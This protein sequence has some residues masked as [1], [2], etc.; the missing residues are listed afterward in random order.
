MMPSLPRFP[1]RRAV[2][3]ALLTC[4]L[5]SPAC[6]SPVAKLGK[7]P[8]APQV[9]AT[10]TRFR[11]EYVLAPGDQIEV[12]VRRA[13][14]ASRTVAVRPDGNISLPLLQDVAAVGL[15]PR[16]LSERLRE[17]LSKRLLDPEVNVIPVQVRQP[18]VY[19]A[20]DVNA[21]AAVPL[22]EA[23]TAVQAITLAG[24]LRRS[25]VSRHVSIIR[26]N[27]EGFVEAIQIPATAKGQPGPYMA[28]RSTLLQPDDLIFV[29]ESGRS[30]S[31]R[32][33]EDFV[34]RP[35][36]G[37]NSVL[38]VYLNFRFVEALAR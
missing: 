28:L 22:R 9:V 10:A 13:P 38:G 35:L 19:V 6:I 36:V 17:G 16:E 30:Q 24:G 20:G 29:A 34:N 1:S 5:F 11:K 33:L 18:M 4:V 25:A 2:L 7:V 37:I 31:A 32:F 14:E 12:V 26:L 3:A 15:T 8:V 21:A 23:P 27:P